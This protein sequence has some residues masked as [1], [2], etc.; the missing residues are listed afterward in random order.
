MLDKFFEKNRKY[1]SPLIRWGVGIVFFLFGIDQVRRPGAWEAYF[2]SALPFGMDLGRAIFLNGLF[3]LAIG[4][5][6]LIGFLTRLVAL[7]GALHLVGVIYYLGY[8]DIAIRDFGLLF[9]ALAVFFYGA[10]WLCL[11]RKIWKRAS[12]DFERS[13]I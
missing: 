3:D 2:P 5:L 7:I 10:D 13:E 4:A 12:Y 6:L 9:G 1:S 11:D 8:G